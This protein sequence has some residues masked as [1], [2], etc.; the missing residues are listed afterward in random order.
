MGKSRTTSRAQVRRRH[1]PANRSGLCYAVLHRPVANMDEI[2]HTASSDSR[3]VPLVVPQ[4]WSYRLRTSQTD[5]RG[6]V[7]VGDSRAY[8]FRDETLH[9]LTRDH[10]VVAEMVHR[11]E[12]DIA[13]ARCAQA[14]ARHHQRRRWNRKPGCRQKLTVLNCASMTS[15]CSALTVSPR[16][17]RTPGISEVLRG[18]P[19][20]EAACTRLISLANEGGGRDNITPIVA[21]FSAVPQQTGECDRQRVAVSGEPTRGIRVTKPPF[22]ERHPM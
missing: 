12:L 19:A 22:P 18:E 20:P 6:C 16:C 13:E 3:S 17:C 2:S 8:L 9:Q 4:P 5:Q 14:P 1:V 15:S 11:G 21:R 10:T 7:L